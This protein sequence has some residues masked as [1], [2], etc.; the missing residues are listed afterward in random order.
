MPAL[1][2]LSSWTC[3]AVEVDFYYRRLAPVDV[4]WPKAR[5][6]KCQGWPF[7]LS[8]F[9]LYENGF[10]RVLHLRVL[11]TRWRLA[12]II[13]A[14][15]VFER[16]SQKIEFAGGFYYRGSACIRMDL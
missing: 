1:A 16:M 6:A 4:G 2:P 3:S 5:A 12:F 13:G 7:L 8:G 14:W 15:L 9:G 10:L 11:A